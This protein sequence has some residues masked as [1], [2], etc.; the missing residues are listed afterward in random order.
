M[1]ALAGYALQDERGSGVDRLLTFD[2]AALVG[3]SHRRAVSLIVER[4]VE[5]GAGSAPSQIA[6]VVGEPGGGKTRVIRDV[7]EGLCELLDSHDRYSDVLPDGSLVADRDGSPLTMPFWWWPVDF[8]NEETLHALAGVEIAQRSADSK[9]RLDSVQFVRAAS[10]WVPVVGQT[11][12]IA[13]LVLAA[14]ENLKAYTA[15]TSH[16]IEE[17]VERL[18]IDLV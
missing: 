8:A 7:F 15:R 11:L 2:D 6:L 4:A 5:I 14:R 9:E 16:S 13:T 1:R 10:N 17:I 12:S 18:V 3:V